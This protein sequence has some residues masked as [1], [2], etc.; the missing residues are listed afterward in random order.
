MRYY[1]TITFKDNHVL[2]EYFNTLKS[3][4]EFLIEDETVKQ[5]T[6]LDNVKSKF[7]YMKNFINVYRIQNIN[8]LLYKDEIF[9]SLKEVHEWFKLECN[10]KNHWAVFYYNGQSVK[11]K[12]LIP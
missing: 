7:I 1:L 10:I 3:V 6:I 9:T 5:I 11:R 8:S 12:I 2:T 4:K